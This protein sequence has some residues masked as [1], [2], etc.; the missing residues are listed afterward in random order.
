MIIRSL[1]QPTYQRSQSGIPGYG[2]SKKQGAD[3]NGKT[4]ED[5]LL[6]AFEGEVVQEGKWFSSNMSDL[7]KR[8]L[9]RL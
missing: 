4:F 8:N 9:E 1:Q 5:Y 2:P 6:E 7:T 3:Q